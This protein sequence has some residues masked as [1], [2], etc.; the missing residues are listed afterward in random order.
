[1]NLGLVGFLKDGPYRLQTL[2]ILQN[3]PNL[4][5]ELAEKL[6]I[7]RASMSRI[8]RELKK[9]DLVVAS[10]TGGRTIVYSISDKGEKILGGLQN[11]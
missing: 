8:L 3:S 2:K 9:K 5:S 7:N 11:Q 6:G 10:S 1:M 4:S